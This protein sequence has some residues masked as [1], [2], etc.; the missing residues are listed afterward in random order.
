MGEQKRD[1]VYVKDV[2][3]AT[4]RALQ[5]PAGVYNVG[6]G[7]ARS[8]NDVIASLNRALGTSLE[9]EYFDN[10]YSFYQPFTEADLTLAR[11]KLRYE[12]RWSLEAGVADYV[13]IGP[14]PT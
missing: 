14:F 11:K 5:A 13:T 1:F 4:L 9:T 3:E 12:P 7:N 10:P 2:V 8:F 6:S